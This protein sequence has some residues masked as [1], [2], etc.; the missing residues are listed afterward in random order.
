MLFV[1]QP[2]E[3]PCTAQRAWT[4]DGESPGVTGQERLSL[5]RGLER[6]ICVGRILLPSHQVRLNDAGIAFQ[7]GTSGMQALGD[8]LLP[9]RGTSRHRQSGRHQRAYCARATHWREFLPCGFAFFENRKRFFKQG[10]GVL[11]FSF[12]K[13]TLPQSAAPPGQMERV[14]VTF[15]E[16]SDPLKSSGAGGIVAAKA[17][18]H[19]LHAQGLSE[20]S[21]VRQL[22]S[23]CQSVA[24]CR[25]L[26]GLPSALTEV[27][28]GGDR[29]I[30]Y[31]N[32]GLCPA[33][34]P[35][36]HASRA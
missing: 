29:S 27:I 19:R 5:G 3:G 2:G 28:H 13:P 18:E 23:D 35:T 34:S 4:T 20:Q 21:L 25:L 1:L 12:A 6:I 9:D 32:E 15:S 7:R 33:R 10:A 31:T 11:Q 26:D 22:F 30:A 16:L 36:W 17:G 24:R 14:A 8:D